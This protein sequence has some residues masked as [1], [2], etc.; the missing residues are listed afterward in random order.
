MLPFYTLVNAVVCFP[1]PRF[2]VIVCATFPHGSRWGT[3]SEF[4]WDWQES[5]L[6]LLCFGNLSLLR[7]S[8]TT[9]LQSHISRA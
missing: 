5:N 8:L 6:R 9:E 3:N 7:R 1:M 4:K 2:R